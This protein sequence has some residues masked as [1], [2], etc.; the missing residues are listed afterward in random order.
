[1]RPPGAQKNAIKPWLKEQWCIPPEQ[2]AEFVC[3]MEDVLDV[4]TAP[5][6]PDEPLVC[7][8]ETSKQLVKE[9]RTPLPME[10]GQPLRYDYEYERNGVAN[11]FLFYE[12]L[13]G[14]RH[15][16]V[17]DRRAK[18]DFAHQMKWL[19]EE[20]HPQARRVK[21]VLD[22][23]NTHSYGSLYEAF[24]PE[25]A[26]RIK[27]RLA[28]IYTPKHGSWLNMAE[29]EFSVLASQCLDRRMGETSFLHQEV[30]AWEQERNARGS[31]I[32]WRFTTEDARIKLKHLYPSLSP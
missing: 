20:R 13:T 19:V 2:S 23:L 31:R 9:S 32:D 6:D 28:F 4:Y 18:V 25:E 22:N 8:D 27:E 14:W 21:V 24:P 30:E 16:E 17:T 1:V 11:L 5:A 10:P 3:A 29:I 12:P 26:R 15:V 7:F